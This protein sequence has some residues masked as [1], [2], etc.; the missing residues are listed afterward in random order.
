MGTQTLPV[1][2]LVNVDLQLT[3]I[4]A[5][6]PN[7][8]TM[9]VLG[10]S[11][12]IDQTTL[13]EEFA[14]LEEVGT[15]FS[16]TDEEYLA[17]EIWFAQ[18]PTPDNIL[19]GAWAKNA[20][21]GQLYCGTLLEA[22]Q[23][24]GPWAAVAN[25]S[26]TISVNGGGALH[27]DGLDFAA[28]GNLNA[29][30]AIINTGLAGDGTCVYDGVNQRFVITSLTTGGA[31]SVSFLT[32]GNAGTDIS[33]MMEGLAASPGAYLAPGV[34]AIS[35]LAAVQEFDNQ[36]SSKWYGLQIPSATAADFAAVAAYI[37]DDTDVP[38]FFGQTSQDPNCYNAASTTDIMYEAMQAAYTKS[39]IQYSS[40]SGYAIASFLARI[41]TTNWNGSNTTITLMFKDEPLITPENLSTTQANAIDAKNGNVYAAYNDGTANIETGVTPS[42]QFVDTVIGCDWL[43]GAVQAACY[44]LLKTM[45]K[46][47]QTD[48]GMHQLGTT[49]ESV[50]NQAVTNG[51]CAPGVWTG[52]G[53]GNLNTGDTLPKGYYV[54]IPPLASQSQADRQARK[55]V[56]IQV[57]I[58]LAGAV[59][60]VDVTL[61]V[62]P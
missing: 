26:F 15:V 28:A 17:A 52:P 48:G 35:A 33:G 46:I 20:T 11:G 13:I 7:L 59:Q 14:D 32:A 45:P 55:S 27:I 57:A 51:L 9:L 41:L 22:N 42:G 34:A 16:T 21:P 39:A 62:N 25:G 54:Y 2:R 60:S 19:I 36:F 47:P 40:T 56:P 10:T 8:S 53:F 1:A 58:K 38:H 30:A 31:S 43:R 61:N 44:G 37:E 50:C 6:F 29:V 4:Q 12:V 23:A 49:I 18:E 3:P 24:I 5:A